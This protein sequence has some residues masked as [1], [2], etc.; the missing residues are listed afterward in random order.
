MAEHYSLRIT[1]YSLGHNL[2]VD[3][4]KSMADEARELAG[5]FLDALGANDERLY[6]QVLHE[7]CLIRVGYWYGSEL[8]RARGRVIRCLMQEWARWPDATVQRLGIIAEGERAA[9]QF[10][11]QATENGRYVEHNRSAILTMQ[12]GAVQ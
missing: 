10:R 1:R 6:E 12:D 5:R 3:R 4:R 9:V 2:R 11:I 7:D 8:Q